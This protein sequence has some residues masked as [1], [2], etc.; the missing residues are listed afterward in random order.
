MSIALWFLSQKIIICL[1]VSR[2]IA[3]RSHVHLLINSLE[4]SNSKQAE[5]KWRFLSSHLGH[6]K[7]GRYQ[8]RLRT[9]AGA[10]GRWA[11]ASSAPF[12]G[13]GIW[14]S[15]K[16]RLP[17]VRWRDLAPELPV[18]CVTLW[19]PHTV[20]S[21]PPRRPYPCVSGIFYAGSCPWRCLLSV[22][23]KHFLGLLCLTL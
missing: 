9:D 14:D 15:G 18:L 22:S 17:Q 23:Q 13:W 21:P 12:W 8:G 4:W 19:P 6:F 5:P 2:L 3:L 1:G 7:G 20:T 16:S 10:S 11:G